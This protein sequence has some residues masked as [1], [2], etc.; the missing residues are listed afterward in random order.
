[1]LTSLLSYSIQINVFFFFKTTIKRVDCICIKD[2]D[3][4]QMLHLCK[5]NGT[6]LNNNSSYVCSCEDGWRGQHCE[7][8]KLHVYNLLN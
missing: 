6:C 4:C 3:E 7:D 2:I 1:M 8:G 5:N